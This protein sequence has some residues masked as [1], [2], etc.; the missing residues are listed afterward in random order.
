MSQLDRTDD[1]LSTNNVMALK[2]RLAVLEERNAELQGHV[3]KKKNHGD[4][5]LIY[6]RAIRRLV[7]LTGRIENM[8][9]EFDRRV[10]LG[11]PED[12]D[13][14]HSVEEKRLY[15]SYKELIRWIPSVQKLINSQSDVYDLALVYGR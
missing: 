14:T 15:Q 1:E 11:D 10:A 12:N 7:C 5:Y 13:R 9:D 6:G 2:R 3:E 8:I 4:P